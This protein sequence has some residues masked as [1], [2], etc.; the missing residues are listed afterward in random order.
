MTHAH[1]GNLWPN[2]PRRIGKATIRAA[3]RQH[4]AGVATG[5]RVRR[6]LQ[7]GLGLLWLLDAAL[8]FQPYMFTKDFPNQ[9]ITPTG[10]GSPGWVEH[11]VSWAAH[12]L[13]GHIVLLNA[14]FALGQLGIAAGLFY[15]PAVRLALA[16]SIAWSLSVWWLGEGLGGMLAGAVSPLQGAPGAV[17]VYL[18]VAVLVWPSRALDPH[19]PSVATASPLGPTGARLVW[20][21]LWAVLA[22]ETL[23]PNDRSPTALHDLVAGNTDGEPEWIKGIDGWAARL[24][25]YRGTEVSIVL[26]VL[27]AVVAAGVFTRL[28]LKPV[29]VLAV[30]LSLTIWVAG[31]DFGALATGHATDP[32]TGPVLALLAATFWPVTYHPPA[33]PTSA[34]TMSAGNGQQHSP[35]S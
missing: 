31:Q 9:V 1:V 26:A 13:A 8:Q 5:S 25:N 30:L 19:R 29:L 21:T 27:F 28:P 32:N 2:R 16:A 10:Q 14:V 24:L 22:L 33:S 15:R 20:L 23:Q 6:R 12:L 18:L 4:G 34:R 17:L 11:P 3:D 35:A 7:I